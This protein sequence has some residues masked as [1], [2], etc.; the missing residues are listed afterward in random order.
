MALIAASMA[1]SAHNPLIEASMNPSF[2]A[3]IQAALIFSAK[4]PV[5]NS[6][7]I[8]VLCDSKK[9]CNQSSQNMI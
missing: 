7:F 1:P 4:T 3:S 8:I 5:C 6:L 2:A 9:I